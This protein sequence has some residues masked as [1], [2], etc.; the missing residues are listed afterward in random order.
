MRP[1]TRFRLGIIGVLG[2]VGVICFLSLFLTPSDAMVLGIGAKAYTYDDVA[3]K[4]VMGKSHAFIPYERSGLTREYAEEI[5]TIIEQFERS[6]NVSITNFS[7]TDTSY[8]VGIW[9][10]FTSKE[11]NR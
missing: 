3:D 2:V 8:I 11:E 1:S 5:I 9:I 6:R 10:T 4:I 7:L